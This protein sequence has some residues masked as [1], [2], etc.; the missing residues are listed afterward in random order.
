[1]SEPAEES[2]DRVTQEAENPV[3]DGNAA[4]RYKTA[5]S[6]KT[7]HTDG[8]D[9][10]YTAIAGYFDLTEENIG[11]ALAQDPSVKAHVFLTQY[12]AD[13]ETDEY[14]NNP[15][16]VIF[17]FNGGPGTSSAWLHLGLFG[18]RIVDVPG[19]NGITAAAPPYHLRDNRQ[20]PLAYAD[21]VV[22]DAISTG[23]S[24]VA[25][26]EI[27]NQYHDADVDIEAMT[28]II[29]LWITRNRRWNS[30]LYIAGE[31]YGVLRGSRVAAR[32]AIRYGVYLSGLILVSSPITIGRMDFGPGKFLGVQAFFPSYAAVAH[33]HGNH[34]ELSLGEVLTKA[35]E[36]ADTKLL[37]ALNQGHRLDEAT[38]NS[39]IGTYADLT[40]L[41]ADFV[42]HAD[43]LVT[44]AQFRAELLRSKGEILGQYDAR[45]IGWNADLLAE[46]PE[47][48]PT[49]QVVRGAFAAGINSYLRQELGY[50][51]DLSYELDT[52]RVRP[53]QVHER[54]G[55]GNPGHVI[56]SL[57]KAI[58]TN[59]TLR[60]LYQ[61]GHYD[62]CTPFYG[63][64]SDVA[65]LQ[66]PAELRGNITISEFDSGH[67]IYLDEKSRIAQSDDIR[68]FIVQAQ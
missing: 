28:N 39:I 31:S 14:G 55:G 9:I 36:F 35:E 40:G 52:R 13:A 19:V 4:E 17:I 65:L 50:E 58:R 32:L 43:L 45:F 64:I 56:A 29:R 48:D 6:R 1:M 21:L 68:R 47:S 5:V 8:T 38:R 63:A 30:P 46:T 66:I 60:V 12:L 42:D 18:P 49:D 54:W 2:I 33:Y 26:G 3:A 67:M 61:V 34:S 11:G 16:P 27:A 20:S 37:W 41:S 57:S 62:L 25:T 10:P 53:W 7:L 23:Y 15:R 59:R 22:I 51:N 24:R 44:P